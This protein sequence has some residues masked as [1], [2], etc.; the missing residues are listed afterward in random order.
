M[1]MSTVE[2]RPHGIRLTGQEQASITPSRS[3]DSARLPARRTR[4]LQAD[5]TSAYSVSGVLLTQG[6]QQA[7]SVQIASKSLQF[8]GKEL[9]TIKRGLTQAMTQGAD[10]VPNLKETLTRSKMTIEA[11]V[12]QARFD[13]QRVVDNE[14]NLKLDRADIR[15]FSIPGLNVN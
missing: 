10:K 4:S 6:Q 15:R 13:G 2:V 12:D 8:V 5:T 3:S 11:V 1:A 14:L 7:T 9:T